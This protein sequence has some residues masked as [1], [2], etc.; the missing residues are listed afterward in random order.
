MLVDDEPFNINALH[1]LM[2]VLKMPHIDKIDASFSGEDAVA[3]MQKAIAE[4]DPDRYG[5]IITDICMPFMDGCVA[6]KTMREMRDAA[7]RD[8]IFSEE[9]NLAIVALTG[10]CE[11]KYIERAKNH[12]IEEVYS[13]P[14]SALELGRLLKRFG[15]L[16]KIPEAVAKH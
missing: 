8:Q 3:L 10:H 13:K 9:S 16:G 4:N 15:Y 11:P 12:G 7:V 14:F 1:G 5:L 2:T 6:A